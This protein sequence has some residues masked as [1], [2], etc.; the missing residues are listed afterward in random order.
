MSGGWW[1]VADGCLV[2]VEPGGGDEAGYAVGHGDGPAA[3][4]VFAVVLAAEQDEVVGVGGSAVGPGGDVVGLA[5]G[6]GSGAA[7]ERA[8]AV[9]RGQRAA[10]AGGGGAAGV[11]VGEHAAGVGE[12]D[13]D[14]VGFGGGG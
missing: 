9:P 14:D 11:A 10:L 7:G 4:V 2:G 5:P 1:R 3:G 13:G 12:D 6:G 8:A